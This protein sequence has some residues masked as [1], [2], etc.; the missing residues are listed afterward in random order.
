MMQH[1]ES[2]SDGA[3]EITLEILSIRLLGIKMVLATWETKEDVLRTSGL[4]G[5]VA[6]VA[7]QIDR[8]CRTRSAVDA[9]AVD[10]SAD[11]R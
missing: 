4:C 9:G 1:W 6:L 11:G 3:V 5:L 2:E 8:A 7:L 10:P